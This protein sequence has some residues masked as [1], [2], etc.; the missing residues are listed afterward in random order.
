MQVSEI[1][2][3][4]ALVR[5]RISGVDYV[6]NPYLGCGHGCR[7]CYAGFM[8]KHSTLGRQFP[9]GEFVEVKI[10]IAEVLRADLSRKRKA[11]RV[12][13]S[14]VCDP[15][16]PLEARYKLTRECLLALREH[17]WEIGIL[18]RS[19]LVLRDV[20]IIKSSLGSSVGMS[21]PT[22]DDEVRK[23]TEPHAPSIASRIETLGK[24]RAAGIETWAFIAPLLPM[25]AKRLHRM[26]APVVGSVMIDRMNYP[27]KVE[28]LFRQNG[29]SD[30]LKPEWQNRTAKELEMLFDRGGGGRQ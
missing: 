23:V 16:Q 11:G 4:H 22:D 19:P 14:S 6:I 20:D 1:T 12:H 27:Y 3:R 26:L 21:V 13:I 2:A 8:T 24:L 25:N 5:S 18:T 15:Y 10:N 9:W 17:G 29:W 28:D 7:Y 30:T